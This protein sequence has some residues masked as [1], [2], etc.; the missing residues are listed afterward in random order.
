MIGM[1]YFE[2]T[3][4]LGSFASHSAAVLMVD[5]AIKTGKPNLKKV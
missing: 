2:N 3:V 1:P 5:N 4:E